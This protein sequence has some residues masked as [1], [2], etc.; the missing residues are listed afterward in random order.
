MIS[1]RDQ[2]ESG[3]VACSWG[4]NGPVPAPTQGS[5]ND[6][7]EA[8]TTEA[9]A[10]LVPAGLHQYN[11][12]QHGKAAGGEGAV[13][14]GHISPGWRQS[15]RPASPPSS[16]SPTRAA[17]SVLPVD[18]RAEIDSLAAAAAIPSA[19]RLR[20]PCMKLDAL[21]WSDLLHSHR[22][23]TLDRPNCA[24]GELS[25]RPDAKPV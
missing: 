14:E 18:P 19:I 20:Q 3:A 2:Q 16:S 13:N 25:R 10:E 15:A 23:R 21:T 4:V 7:R 9:G 1:K 22:S 6:Q 17:W 24:P 12:H 5:L 8:Q 11:G